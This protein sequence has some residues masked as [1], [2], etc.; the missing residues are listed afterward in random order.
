MSTAILDRERTVR[1]ESS[2][3]S[4]AGFRV[5]IK[6]VSSS[7]D[8]AIERIVAAAPPLSDAQRDRLATILGGGA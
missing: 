3:D 7:V 6:P 1:K 4:A 2:T 5:P 8:A